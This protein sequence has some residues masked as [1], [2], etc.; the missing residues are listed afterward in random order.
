MDSE[1]GRPIPFTVVGGY[2][3]SGKTTLINRLLAAAAGRRIAVLVNDFGAVNIDARLVRASDGETLELANG[4]ICCS[5]S[6]G[7]AAALGSVLSRP[8]RPDHIVVEASGIAD[9][10]R[11]AQI[12]LTPGLELDGIVVLADA[13]TVRARAVERYVGDVVCDQLR[14]ADLVVLNRTDLAGEGER[15]RTVAWLRELVPDARVVQTTFGD[16]PAELLLGIGRPSP[17]GLAGVCAEGRHA[18][19]ESGFASVVLSAGEPLGRA[20]LGAL[21]AGLPVGIYRAKG[22]VDLDDEPERRTLL[23]L[24]GRRWSLTPGEPWRGDSR[25]SEV[26]VIGAAASFA[27][28]DLAERFTRC[29]LAVDREVTR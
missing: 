25:R 21:L 5:L 10:W 29:S 12:G 13:E 8:R 1:A 9:P 6:N 7:F 4:C 26:V 17:A 27:A 20:A 22:F 19:H 3:G 16:V 2:L 15:G 23:Q 18:V 11:I 28:D 14:V 24:V